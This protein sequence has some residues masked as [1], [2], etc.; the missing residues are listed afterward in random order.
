ML[1]CLDFDFRPILKM[2]LM[3]PM[4]TNLVG[5][6]MAEYG[7]PN[8]MMG[9]FVIQALASQDPIIAEGVLLLTQC[10]AGNVPDDSTVAH[11]LEKLSV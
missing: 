9:V 4:V 8:V 3:L 1:T 10:S 7:F 11:F 5:P 2:Q 6:K